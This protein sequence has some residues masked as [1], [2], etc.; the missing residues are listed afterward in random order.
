MMMNPSH[1]GLPVNGLSD[2][3][4]CCWGKILV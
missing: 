2:I 4:I 3:F 1:Q